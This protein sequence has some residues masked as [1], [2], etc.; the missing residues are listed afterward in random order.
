[1][2][3][4]LLELH[5]EIRMSIYVG[6]TGPPASGKEVLKNRLIALLQSRGISNYYWSISNYVREETERIHGEYTREKLTLVSKQ[7]KETFG[8][9]I[10]AVRACEQ[11]T[12]L[13]NHA[14]VII[15]EAIKSSDEIKYFRSQWNRSFVLLGISAPLEVLI[16]RIITRKRYDEDV[17]VLRDTA[18][19]KRMIDGEYGDDP[20]LGFDIRHC[21]EICDY[22]IDNKGSLLELE[23]EAEKFFIGVIAPLL[24]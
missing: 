22:V 24:R 19:T 16:Q 5:H 14:D 4:E 20:S 10:M 13:K 3:F 1:L 23:Q 12:K 21:L 9:D 18:A 17:N 11:V 6:I 15:V 2:E 7:L 8:P